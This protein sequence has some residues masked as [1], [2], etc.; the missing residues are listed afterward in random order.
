MTG[1]WLAITYVAGVVVTF[2]IGIWSE[3]SAARREARE[4]KDNF[5]ELI[6]FISFLWPLVLLVLIFASAL[7]GWQWFVFRLLGT[8]SD[9][10]NGDASGMAKTDGEDSPDRA[11]RREE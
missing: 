11:V 6:F 1:Q 9:K 4:P 8:G 7:W 2:C 3:R 10:E 5:P